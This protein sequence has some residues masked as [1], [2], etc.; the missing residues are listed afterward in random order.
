[1]AISLH[2]AV[3]PTWLQIIGSVRRLVDKAEA[4]CA[5]GK[6][7]EADLLGARLADD[8]LPFAY[9]VKSCHSHSALAIEGVRAG[10]FSPAML[11]P[12]DSFDGL[13]AKL[14]EARE[15]LESVDPDELESIAGNDMVFSIGDRLRLEFTVQNFLLS[16]S[17]PN[18]HFHAATAYDILRSQ[19]VQIG[20]QDFLGSLRL[21]PA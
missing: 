19:G 3:V 5:E 11:P 15:V 7:S 14:D 12:P 17:N 20:K 10:A 6:A 21:K 16:F 1:M 2:E 4:F 8:M 13:R 18:F 9:Q